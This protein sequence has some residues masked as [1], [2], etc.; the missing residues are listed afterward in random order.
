M[1]KSSLCGTQV[2]NTNTFESDQTNK[3]I[4]I[5]HKLNCKSSLVIYQMECTLCKIQYV[6]KAE[7]AFNI[8]L[9]NH[10]KDANGNSPKAIPESIHFKQKTCEI[11]SYKTN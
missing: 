4:K 7:T 11:H 8:K 1:S 2:V 9:H 3:A 6:G 10:R 5:F